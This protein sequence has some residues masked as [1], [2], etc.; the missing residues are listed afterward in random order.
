M[1]TKTFILSCLLVAAQGFSQDNY[2]TKLNDNKVNRENLSPRWVFPKKFSLYQLDLDKIKN[3]L[4]N[5]AQR[6]SNNESL[7]V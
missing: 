6:F 5:A 1:K 4:K 2:W 3:D 7:I